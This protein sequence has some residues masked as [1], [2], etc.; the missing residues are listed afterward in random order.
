MPIHE[1]KRVPVKDWSPEEHQTWTLLFN[2]LEKS[3]RSQA[4]PEFARGVEVLGFTG[5]H[6]PDLEEVNRK[7]K[8]LTGWEAVPVEGLEESAS[9]YPMMAKKQYPIGNFIRDP[10]D[11]SYTPAP[12]IFHDMYG[13]MPFFAHEPFAE[14]CEEFGKR[15]SRYLDRPDCL[16]QWERLFWLTGEF[17]LLDTPDGRR[18]FGGG[19][20]SSFTECDF[21]LSE[22]PTVHPFDLEHIR[23]TSFRIDILQ[24]TLFV[25]PT[26]E[27]LYDCLEAFEAPMK[28]T[29]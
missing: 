7:L 25:M 8:A 4:V 2:N 29:A 9:F 14:W 6:I 23:R 24:E 18:I 10:K 19:I 26:R 16:E 15:A 22:K 11:L 20:L 13:H 5:D 17:G 1:P 28:G 27:S 21:A 12:D 3:R